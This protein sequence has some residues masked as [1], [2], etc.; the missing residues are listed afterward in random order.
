VN[1]KIWLLAATLVLVAGKIIWYYYSN[2]GLITIHANKQP[3]SQIIS[4]IQ[5]Q[6]H[7][8]LKTN[9]DPG[10]PVTM[11]VDR[12]PVSD[13]LET[14]S[15]VTESRWRL[16][17]FL[18]PDKAMLRAGIEAIAAGKKPDDWRVIDYPFP[19]LFLPASGII[20][21]PRR[22]EW[23]SKA[24][25]ENT[26]QARL[27]GA[28]KRTHVGFALPEK[29]NPAISFTLR[30]GLIAQVMPK[31]AGGIH[32]KMEPVFLLSKIERRPRRGDGGPPDGGQDGVGFPAGPGRN[33]EVMAE[34]GLAEIK[35]LPE[36]EQAAAKAEFDRQQAFFKAIR[37]LP[38][39]QRR[40][41][42]EERMNDPQVQQQMENRQSQRDARTTPQQKLQRAQ[43]Y[44][45][46]KQSI[47]NP[48][49]P[50][51]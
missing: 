30:S 3:L 7:V 17:Y 9:L 32:G 31:L 38:P 51:P 34:R 47:R 11:D 33:F 46:R 15:V 14:L 36:E 16:N 1:R 49:S 12:V 40:A 6:G 20:P 50:A 23:P 41:K 21:D 42:M 29:W 10:T 45:D 8:I 24:P 37:D 27:E 4:R 43:R 18:A 26:L 5:R 13:A 25:E 22:D 2:W 35:R 19:R 48:Q 28:A 44:V 39:E